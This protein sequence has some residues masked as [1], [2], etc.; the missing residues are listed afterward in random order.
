MAKPVT[1]L[2]PFAGVNNRLPDHQ[3]A[4]VER[5]RKAGDY[6]R[7]AVN[8]DLT[9]AGTLLRRKGSTLA[10]PGASCHSLWSDGD[11]AFFV[12]GN[13]IKA[14]PE[15]NTVQEGLTYG[16]PVSWCRLPNGLVAWSNGAEL[17][18]ID[19]GVSTA[20]PVIPN[21]AP[22]VRAG[23]GGSLHG[24]VY[25]V[26]I[27]GLDGAGRE[28]GATW[29]AQVQVPEAGT[30]EIS[31]LP[32]TRVN[33]YVSPLNGDTLFYVMTT[34]AS[35]FTFSVTPIAF[36]RQLDL[37]G[38]L[39]I[40]PGS[41]V[42]Y[43]HG[44]LLTATPQQLYYSEPFAYWLYNPLRNRIPLAGLTLVEP[45]EGGL[46]LATED[47]TWWLPG[48]DIDQPERLV[49]I[50]PYGAVRGAVTRSNNNAQVLWFSKRGLVVGDA[51]GQVK[52][53]QEDALAIRPGRTGAMLLREEDGMRQAV[54]SVFGAEDTRAGVRSFMEA[55][56]VRKES[57]L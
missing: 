1:T 21:P 47:K 32:G 33:L 5:G 8:V 22:T 37:V 46:Y 29:P 14:L 17:G 24:G 39:P 41:V 51:Q 40:P 34:S 25:Q 49:E 31:D 13:T 36:G 27:T 9:D 7:N 48:A 50:L 55:E 6:L 38:L 42:R 4:I 26:A 28:S 52:N 15:G 16:K 12:D 20:P 3:L 18:F 43:Y 19:Q 35:S 11:V 54:A 10:H 56:I 30:I 23:T 2:G 53:L 44:R 45:V 57:M